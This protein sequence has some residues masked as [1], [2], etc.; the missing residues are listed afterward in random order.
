MTYLPLLHESTR[1]LA[2]SREHKAGYGVGELVPVSITPGGAA[3]VTSPQG[4]ETLLR[5]TAAGAAFYQA[6]DQP[7]FYET[8]SGNWWSSFAVNVS[9]Q[10]SDLTGTAL[11][12]VRDRVATSETPQV[13]AQAQQASPLRVQLEKSQQSWWWIP[14]QP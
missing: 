9:A 8:R 13:T 2:G 3:R 6:T 7:G 1:Y 14:S 10:E 5:S 12:D 11:E 4:E